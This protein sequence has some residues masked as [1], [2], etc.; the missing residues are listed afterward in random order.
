MDDCQSTACN[1]PQGDVLGTGCDKREELV[2]HVMCACSWAAP[3]RLDRCQQNHL[4]CWVVAR[5]GCDE[6]IDFV[7]CVSQLVVGICWRQL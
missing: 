4:Q 2:V 1:T 3:S 6:R 5:V 7:D